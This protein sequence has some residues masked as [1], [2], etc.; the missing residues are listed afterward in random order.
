M[1][2]E[3]KTKKDAIGFQEEIEKHGYLT[4]IANSKINQK[5]LSLGEKKYDA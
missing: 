1:L 3:F 2:Y 5:R 4:S